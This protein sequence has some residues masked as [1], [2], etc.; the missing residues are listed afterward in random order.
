MIKFANS[1]VRLSQS[2][3]MEVCALSASG[4]TWLHV[5]KENDEVV[6]IAYNK[7]RQET[8]KVYGILPS[9]LLKAHNCEK[10]TLVVPVTS[11]VENFIN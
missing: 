11:L 1:T 10:G 3:M 9:M 4:A 7:K 6:A 8:A 2:E 5:L